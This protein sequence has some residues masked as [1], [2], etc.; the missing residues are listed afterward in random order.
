M[1]YKKIPEI[2]ENSCLGCAFQDDPDECG[3]LICGDNSIYV[4]ICPYDDRTETFKCGGE[5]T[6]Y[7]WN[8]DKLNFCPFCGKAVR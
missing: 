4:E 6:G 3:G 7:A 5:L 8:G 1:N 2:E